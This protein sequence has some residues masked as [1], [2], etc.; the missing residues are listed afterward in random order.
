MASN[1]Q[2]LV[3]S[4]VMTRVKS[5]G[6]ANEAEK[7]SRRGLSPVVWLIIAV[8]VGI[9]FGLMLSSGLGLDKKSPMVTVLSLPGML[10]LK[11]LKCIV[12][13]M[14]VFSMIGAMVMLRSL[15]GAKYLGFLVV[16]VYLLTTFVAAMEGCVVASAILGPNVKEMAVEAAAADVGVTQLTLLETVVTMLSNLVPKNVVNDAATNNLLPVIIASIIFGLLVQ[17]KKEDGTQSLTMG[18]IKELEQV[19]VKVI[20]GLMTITPLGVGS[21][22]FGSAASLNFAE[23]GTNVG[24]HMAAVACGLVLHMFVFYP[25]LLLLVARRNPIPYYMNIVPAFATALGT[26]SSAATLPVS[27]SCAVEKNM[28]SPHIANF[29]LNLGATINMDGTTIYL[30]CATYFLG[31]LHGVVFTAGKFLLLVLL[32]TLCSMGSAPLPSASLVLLVTILTSVGVP[33]NET[34]GLITAVDWMLDRLRTT[35]NVAGDACAAAIIDS[36]SSLGT[37]ACCEPSEV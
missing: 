18:L 1:G 16:G 23:V 31:M 25:T 30:I 19:V 29:V 15:P 11:A 33:L 21:L 12:L 24:F 13:P 34:F 35:V 26:S 28:I 9:S 32:G 8:V 14:I 10:W 7:K 4:E 3:G 17:D 6:Q 36:R 27:I 22:V 2:D 5:S 20:T 37:K